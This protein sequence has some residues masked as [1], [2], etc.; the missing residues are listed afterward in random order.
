MAPLDMPRFTDLKPE[1]KPAK[2]PKSKRSISKKTAEVYARRKANQESKKQQLEIAAQL[3]KTIDKEKPAKVLILELREMD[4]C[5][6]VIARIIGCTYGYVR[7]LCADLGMTNH[8][9][10]NK[11]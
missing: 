11:R 6:K 9:L 3:A 2:P 5:Y 1:P 8:A 4:L 10:Q 7:T